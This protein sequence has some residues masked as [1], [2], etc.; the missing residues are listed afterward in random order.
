MLD[1][2]RLAILTRPGWPGT[3]GRTVVVDPH[4]ITITHGGPNRS[5]VL[6]PDDNDDA[7]LNAATASGARVSP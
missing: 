5:R 6:A 1:A 7:A 3:A 2:D 4:T